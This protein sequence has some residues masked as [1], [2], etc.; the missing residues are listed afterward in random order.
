M[1]N[2]TVPVLPAKSNGCF[3][4]IANTVTV[5]ASYAPVGLSLLAS[6]SWP[7]QIIIS[8]GGETV[9]VPLQVCS[10]VVA[11]QPLYA[12]VPKLVLPVAR[13]TPQRLGSRSPVR[14]G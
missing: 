1:S 12:P 6:R 10:W 13:D 11:A 3:G 4:Y 7:L 8:L 9:I 14:L 2:E 5:P